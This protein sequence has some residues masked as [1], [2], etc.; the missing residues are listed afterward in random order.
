MIPNFNFIVFNEAEHSY[1]NTRTNKY[2]PSVTTVLDR[3]KKKDKDKM[4]KAGVAKTGIPADILSWM[5]KT[6]NNVA[7]NYGSRVHKYIED[8]CDLKEAKG[9]FPSVDKYFEDCHKDITV[10]SEFRVGN[11]LIAGTFDNLT[12][13]DGKFILKDWKT[14]AVMTTQSPY[15]LDYPFR[16]LDDSKLTLYSLQ[17][18]MYRLLLGIEI[19]SMEVVHFGAKDYTVYTVPYMEA[20]VKKILKNLHNDNS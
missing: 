5:W 13:R 4:L 16:H 8:I 12:L 20:E 3:L 10:H 18:S 6:K 15:K 1:F 17:L 9:H 7:T 2:V 11:D 19:E 14:N